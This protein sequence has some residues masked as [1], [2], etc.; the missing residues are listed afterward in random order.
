MMSA[1]SKEEMVLELADAMKDA[2]AAWFNAQK[3]DDDGQKITIIMSALLTNVA[4]AT[5][6]LADDESGLL[7]R[8][9]NISVLLRELTCDWFVHARRQR[10]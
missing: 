6:L 1:K 2:T 10:Q 7:D 9:N 3:F 8:I 4:H 5:V